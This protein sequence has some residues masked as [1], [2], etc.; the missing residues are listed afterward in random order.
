MLTEQREKVNSASEKTKTKKEKKRRECEKNVKKC[1]KIKF[2][3]FCK[4]VNF[5]QFVTLQHN[6]DSREEK[7][8]KIRVKHLCSKSE[9][10]YVQSKRLCA[11]FRLTDMYGKEKLLEVQRP[12]F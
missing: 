3:H 11:V 5:F 4:F 6:G 12:L 10:N 8:L 1:E 2:L 9:P 7:C